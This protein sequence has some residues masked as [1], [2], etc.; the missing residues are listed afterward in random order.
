LALAAA[1]ERFQGT[2]G[3]IV[4]RRSRFLRSASP[5]IPCDRL[6]PATISYESAKP[7]ALLEEER[8]IGALRL[9]ISASNVRITPV[10]AVFAE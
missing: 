6:A 3:S 8:V 4:D 5:P 1:I 9:S 2:A 7:A 10:E